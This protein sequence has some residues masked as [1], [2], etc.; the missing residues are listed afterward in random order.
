MVLVASTPRL[1]VTTGGEVEFV[2]DRLGKDCVVWL[3]RFVRK[4]MS[5][6]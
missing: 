4:Y 2:A 6:V 1:A 3:S 5:F